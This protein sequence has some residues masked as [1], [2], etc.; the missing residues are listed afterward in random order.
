[1][2]ITHIISQ[3]FIE[4]FV[5]IFEVLYRLSLQLTGNAAYSIIPLSL[6]VNILCLPLYN[7]AERIQKENRAL[8]KKMEPWRQ[9]IKAHFK[10]DERFMMMQMYYKTCGYNPLFVLRNSI[11][12][13]LQ[14]PLFIAAYRVLSTTPYL[15]GE[16]FGLI[17][18]L[19]APDC[20]LVIGNLTMNLLPIIM[21]IIN[22][23]SGIIYTKNDSTI[24]DKVQVYAIA[25]LFLVLLYNSPSG[26]VLYWIFNQLFSLIKNVIYTSE[27]K[28]KYEHMVNYVLSI[29]GILYIIQSIIFSLSCRDYGSSLEMIVLGILLQVPLLLSRMRQFNT[30]ENSYTDCKRQG[31]SYDNF[32]FYVGCICI[33]VLTGILIPSE[34]IKSSAMEFTNIWDYHSPIRFL[35]DAMMIAGGLFGVWFSVFYYLSDYGIRH[36]ESMIVFALL[37]VF[38]VNYFFFG[39]NLGTMSS[40]LQFAEAPFYSDNEKMVNT[41]VFIFI[42][43]FSIFVGIKLRETMSA[44]LIIILLILTAKSVNNITL[45]SKEVPGIELIVKQEE[46]AQRASIPLSKKGKNVIVLMM[47]R[48]INSF[49]P[50]LFNENPELEEMFAGFSYYPNTISYGNVTYLGSPGVYGGYDYTPENSNRRGDVSLREKQNEALLVMPLLFLQAGYDVTVCDP[51]LA[52]YSFIPDLSIFDQYT[53]VRAYNTINGQFT[54]EDNSKAAKLEIWTN[55]IFR[56]SIMKVSPVV[57]QKFLYDNSIFLN[58]EYQTLVSSVSQITDGLSRAKGIREGFI[59]SYSVLCE[60]PEITEISDRISNTFLMLTNCSTHEPILLQE[61]QYEPSVDVDNTLYD[62][63]YEGRFALNGRIL[64]VDN[65]IQMGS[66]QGHMASLEKLGEWFEYLREQGVYD[67]TRIIIVADHGHCLS[68]FFDMRFGDQYYEDAM[69]YNPVLMVKDFYSNE[70]TVDD[71]FMTNCDTPYLAMKDL[72]SEPHNPFTGNLISIDG[73]NEKE[74]MIYSTYVFSTPKNKEAY[75][76]TDGRI[77]LLHGDDIFDMNAWK[78][79]GDY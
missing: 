5:L 38:V 3:I 41:T 56:Y 45:I 16:S 31:Y 14:V 20:L 71:S 73:K 19:G 61:P 63:M 30:D 24:R 6:A 26:L 77:F 42:I 36:I 76:F 34:L 2:T 62:K 35:I 40:K 4:P 70:Y 47:D 44:F 48:C 13:F 37:I 69:W 57:F 12:L 9:H 46:K 27:S 75:T 1:M 74:H 25:L 18:D 55:N 58:T 33:I 10:G 7:R 59:N 32:I 60:L 66:Y 51:S 50:Y 21:S 29:G 23:L 15:Q 17:I 22:I 72:I 78:Y 68:D 53:G 8:E 39:T 79:A 11:S 54:S 52:N 43:T 49:I 65:E 64:S 28:T 67:N